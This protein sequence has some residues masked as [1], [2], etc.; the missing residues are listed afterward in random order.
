MKKVLC[1]GTVLLCTPCPACCTHWK[2][3]PSSWRQHW[4]KGLTSDADRFSLCN[5]AYCRNTNGLKYICGKERVFRH[6]RNVTLSYK[7]K[8]KIKSHKSQTY[9][10]V[11]YVNVVHTVFALGN[12]LI[13]LC[14]FTLWKSVSS[15]RNRVIHNLTYTVDI[16]H[17]SH[18]LL[19][20]TL[21]QLLLSFYCCIAC[22]WILN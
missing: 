4:L 5:V 8:G 7:R 12:S 13:F 18:P 20:L 6:V 9:C 10:L 16:F 17:S 21:G 19:Y 1:C 2:S 14:L 3:S 11:H 15:R 22:T